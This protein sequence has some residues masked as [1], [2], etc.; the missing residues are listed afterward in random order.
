MLNSGKKKL[1]SLCADSTESGE[2]GDKKKKMAIFKHFDMLEGFWLYS[3]VWCRANTLCWFLFCSVFIGGL[4]T[5]FYQPVILKYIVMKLLLRTILTAALVVMLPRTNSVG[6]LSLGVDGLW[7]HIKTWL[8]DTSYL[9]HV[10]CFVCPWVQTAP[11]WK[12]AMCIWLWTLWSAPSALSSD[13]WRP[14]E[15]EC[16]LALDRCGTEFNHHITIRP[17]SALC[18]CERRF[19]LHAIVTVAPSG[20][21]LQRL[22]ALTFLFCSISSTSYI[23]IWLYNYLY[24]AQVW[25]MCTSNVSWGLTSTWIQQV[26]GRKI[27]LRSKTEQMMYSCIDLLGHC[28]CSLKHIRAQMIS[29]WMLSVKPLRVLFRPHKVFAS[30]NHKVVVQNSLVESLEE[31]QKIITDILYTSMEQGL[32]S[33]FLPKRSF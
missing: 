11:W 18:G 24:L 2:K 9:S 21:M 25:P 15:L 28:S 7:T 30:N 6:W 29:T 27:A 33:P 14:L 19:T 20:E 23:L 17:S 31:R 5:S 1:I 10:L 12:Q 26:F 22:V 3:F 13:V 8:S 4:Q 32:A 16:T